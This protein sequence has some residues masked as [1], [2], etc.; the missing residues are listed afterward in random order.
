MFTRW[1]KL[2]LKI[3]RMSFHFLVKFHLLYWELKFK[4]I[5]WV[6][7]VQPDITL[8][9]DVIFKLWWF[10]IS[11]P[12]SCQSDNTIW[13]VSS[14]KAYVE[15]PFYFFVGST[16]LINHI[17]TIILFGLFVHLWWIFFSEYHNQLSPL[18]QLTMI[19]ILL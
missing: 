4:P 18:F 16:V 9:N 1:I 5:I 7:I 12:P 15:D 13:F 2:K 17:I 6:L 10:R 19:I 14:I 3:L 8:Q 11:H